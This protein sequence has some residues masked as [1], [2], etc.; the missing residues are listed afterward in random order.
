MLKKYL[1]ACCLPSNFARNFNNFVKLRGQKATLLFQNLL[2]YY[3]FYFACFLSFG[4]NKT[5]IEMLI[6]EQ[7][8]NQINQIKSNQVKNPN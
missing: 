7:N 5:E 8:K 3:F 1:Y 2:I 4:L 6:V